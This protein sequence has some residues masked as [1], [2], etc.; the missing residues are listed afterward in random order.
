ME[1]S[2]AGVH[3]T[4]RKAEKPMSTLIPIVY[5]SEQKAEE[6][7]SLLFDLSKRYLVK[8]GDIVIATRPRPVLASVSAVVGLGRGQQRESK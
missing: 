2:D 1:A 6:V 8:L 7:R 5:A 4:I 3:L